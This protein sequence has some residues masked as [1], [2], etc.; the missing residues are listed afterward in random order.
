MSFCRMLSRSVLW[1]YGFLIFSAI[2]M[3]DSLRTLDDKQ[4][5]PPSKIPDNALNPRRSIVRRK[6]VLYHNFFRTKVR[7]SASNMLLMS[8]HEGAARQAQRYAEQCVFL[9]HNDPREN[10]V[11][12]LGACGQNLFVAAQKTPWFFALKT[13][14][15]EYKNF[16]Y[17][18]PVHNLKA[19]GHYTQMVWATSHKLGCGLAHCPG[20]PWGHFYNYV[21]HYCPAGN[22]DTITQ[23]PYKVGS[24][25]GDCPN[26]CISG[27]LCTN[28]CPLKDYYSNCDQ[29]VELTDICGQGVCNATCTCGSTRLY[30]NYPW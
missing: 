14:F 13:W 2:L 10:T 21:C 20:G 26:D 25:C 18:A 24:P 16:T 23:Y 29:L 11:R 1:I 15:L 8:W 27:E 17:G 12:N 4:L 19:V 9:Q 7:P 22:F 30:K 5:F 28:S 3:L 6:I